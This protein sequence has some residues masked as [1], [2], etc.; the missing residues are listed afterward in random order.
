MTKWVEV[1]LVPIRLETGL[2]GG[3]VGIEVDDR[4]VR[5][6]LSNTR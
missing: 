5:S 2:M 4:S 6:T 3:N 1:Y